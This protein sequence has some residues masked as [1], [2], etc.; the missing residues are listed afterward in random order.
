MNARNNRVQYK[1]LTTKEKEQFKLEFIRDTIY[2]VNCINS[3]DMVTLGVDSKFNDDSIYQMIFKTDQWYSIDY[4]AGVQRF[5]GKKLK[6]ISNTNTDRPFFE[7]INE[8]RF[9]IHLNEITHIEPIFEPNLS[10][11][12]YVDGEYQQIIT[13][14]CPKCARFFEIHRGNCGFEKTSGIVDFECN[15]CETQF[16]VEY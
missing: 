12:K 13:F 4:R 15:D 6:P 14:D 10:E 11:F 2:K 1:F 5:S 7:D 16:K 3:L 8:N 9:Q